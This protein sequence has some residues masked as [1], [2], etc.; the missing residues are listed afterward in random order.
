VDTALIADAAARAREILAEHHV[1][2]LPEEVDRLIDSA[3]KK[4]RAAVA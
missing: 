4:Y 3:I 2:P 1:E